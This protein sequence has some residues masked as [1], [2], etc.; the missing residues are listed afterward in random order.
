MIGAT[1][2]AWDHSP[3]YC[4]VVICKNSRFHHK[5]SHNH[6]H[7]IPLAETD[8]YESLPIFRGNFVVRCDNCGKEYSYQPAEVL[9]YELDLPPSFAP[10]PLF[11]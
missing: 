9:R 5:N 6:T 10:H 8:P 7:K 1:R 2:P 11:V 4:W 3:P